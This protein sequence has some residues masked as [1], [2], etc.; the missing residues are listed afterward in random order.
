M[1]AARGLKCS[2]A[3]HASEAHAKVAKRRTPQSGLVIYW[4]RLCR[5]FHLGHK[6]GEQKRRNSMG[7]EKRGRKGEA[8]Q[9]IPTDLWRELVP[10]MV[11]L[12]GPLQADLW[13]ALIGGNWAEYDVKRARVQALLDRY[14]AIRTLEPAIAADDAGW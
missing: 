11:E 6:V 5:A 4:C 2:K 8:K 9:G 3:R 12:R 7:N 14:D 10:L 1:G 13:R